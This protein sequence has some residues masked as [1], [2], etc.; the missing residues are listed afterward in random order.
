MCPY[1]AVPYMETVLTPTPRFSHNANCMNHT[2][3]LWAIRTRLLVGRKHAKMLFCTH[4]TPKCGTLP[5][6]APQS[7]ELSVIE[8]VG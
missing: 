8:A 2:A 7:H 6:N 1:Y 4:K 5:L 3:I